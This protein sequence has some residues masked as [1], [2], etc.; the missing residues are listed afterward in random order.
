V[1]P[2]RL[3]THMAA[4]RPHPRSSHR[5]AVCVLMASLLLLL[6]PAADA[7]V[8]IRNLD[9][10]APPWVR[11][12]VVTSSPSRRSPR[13]L[14]NGS[15]VAGLIAVNLARDKKIV[16][17]VD[18]SQSMHGQ[19]L[20][21][22]ARAAQRFIALSS[23]GDQSAVVT[24]ASRTTV[25]A[26]FGTSGDAAAALDG[27]KVDPVYGTTLYDAVVLGS[28]LLASTGTG[29]RVMVVVTDGQETTS[30]A[31]L[32]EA[33]RTA[34]HAHVSVYP[35]AIETASLSP[36]PLRLL[37]SRTGGAYHAVRTT[38]AL[39][40]I[41][42][43][44]STELRRTW[45]VRYLTAARTGERIH[46]KVIVPSRGSASRSAAMAG[47]AVSAGSGSFPLLLVA[48][49]VLAAVLVGL[50]LLPVVRMVGSL[51]RVGADGDF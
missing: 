1:R 6:A 50:A 8:V 35:V 20:R 36:A 38:S 47:R 30:H 26:G 7:R 22:A 32:A 40:A 10:S 14:E 3:M 43:S 16:L 24:F 2:P 9:T 12:T 15:P 28:R 21:D 4:R 31:S 41:Y 45:Q 19:A 39:A 37:A 25:D 51:R 11:M 42:A 17:A 29:G 5:I 23:S 18:H 13:V 27:L 46:V 33:I 44:I 48:A 34:R 49:L